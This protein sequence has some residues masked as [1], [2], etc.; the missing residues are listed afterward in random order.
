MKPALVFVHGINT[1]PAERAALPAWLERRVTEH[2]VGGV[3]R[4]MHVAT[5]DSAGN[6]MADL[7]NLGAHAAVRKGA[8]ESIWKHLV[9]VFRKGEWA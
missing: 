9:P 2:G 8:V 3:F 4:S 6:F 5:W 7:A 1:G